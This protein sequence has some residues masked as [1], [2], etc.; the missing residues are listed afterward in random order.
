MIY[1]FDAR[2]GDLIWHYETGSLVYSTPAYANRHLLIGS[3]DG[4]LYCF[5]QAHP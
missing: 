1:G 2:Q 4:Y 3:H 5:R